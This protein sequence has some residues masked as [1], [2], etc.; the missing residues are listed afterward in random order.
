MTK[1]TFG[2]FAGVFT[3][4]TLT[5][6]GVIMFI[7]EPWVV[8]NA[9]LMGALIIVLLSVA[10]TLTTALSLSSIT[11][12]VRIGAGG[13]FSLISQSLGLEIGGAIGIPFYFA[14]AIAVAMYIFGFREGMQTIFPGVAPILLDMGIFCLVMSIAFISTSFAFKIQYV[15]L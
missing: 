15:I 10:I 1:K 4:T 6:L 14:Q 11:T 7:R 12:N 2:T 8:G 9:G 13:A 3:P 5:I